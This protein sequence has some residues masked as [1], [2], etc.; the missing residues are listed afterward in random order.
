MPAKW[1]SVKNSVDDALDLPKGSLM[2][3][4]GFLCEVSFY[5]HEVAEIA[6]ALKEKSVDADVY[7][8]AGLMILG[9]KQELECMSEYAPLSGG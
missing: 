2:A 6:T 1:N 9:Q 8:Q 4:F 5:P 3:N 7:T